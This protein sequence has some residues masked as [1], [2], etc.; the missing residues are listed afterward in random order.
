MPRRFKL[1]DNIVTSSVTP[2][3]KLSDSG[4]LMTL[5]FPVR[6]ATIPQDDKPEEK[7]DKRHSHRDLREPDGGTIFGSQL[8]ATFESIGKDETV[9]TISMKV[10]S[11]VPGTGG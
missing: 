4:D 1:G 10:N 11:K 2:S 5:T 3:L 6:S 8:V 9:F 7:N